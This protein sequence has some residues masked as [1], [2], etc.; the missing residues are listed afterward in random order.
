[1]YTLEIREQVHTMLDEAYQWY[2]DQLPGL[3]ERLLEEVEDRL[4]DLEEHPQY[5]SFLSGNYRMAL[6]H[7]FPFKIVFE[8]YGTIVVVYAI[9]HTSREDTKFR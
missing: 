9:F 4:S 8:I 2:E 1:M 6:L 3:G 7:R 5:Y